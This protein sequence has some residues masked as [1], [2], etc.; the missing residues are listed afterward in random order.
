M[1]CWH[2]QNVRLTA[3]TQE[4]RRGNRPAAILIASNSRQKG[5]ILWQNLRM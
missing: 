5:M 4:T 2:Q 3:D 1:F